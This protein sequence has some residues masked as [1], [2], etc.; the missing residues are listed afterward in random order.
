MK[1]AIVALIV[2]CALGYRWGYTEGTEGVPS[3]VS[4]TLDRFGT[5][6]VKAAQEAQEKRVMEAGRP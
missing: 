2:G 5:S 6:K 1:R 4:R 3:I